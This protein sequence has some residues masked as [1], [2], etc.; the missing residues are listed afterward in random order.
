MCWVLELIDLGLLILVWIVVAL[1]VA[2]GDIMLE[3][4]VFA[5]LS[6]PVELLVL[7]TRSFQIHLVT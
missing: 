1:N 6:F 2:Q 5:L 7:Y 4:I 3:R